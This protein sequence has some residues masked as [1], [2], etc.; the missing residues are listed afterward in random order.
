MKTILSNI[1]EILILL[2][3]LITLLQSGWD[4]ISDWSGNLSWLKGHFAESPFK[5]MVPAL[6]G[7]L[8]VFELVSGLLCLLGI[9]QLALNDDANLALYAAILSA[10]TLLMLLFGQRI[11][12]DY[13]GARTIIVYFIPTVFLVFL[14]SS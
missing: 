12:K 11:A 13:E 6:L 7:T 5:N 3:L 1:T 14:L 10:I 2:M 9:Y 8:L 4:K